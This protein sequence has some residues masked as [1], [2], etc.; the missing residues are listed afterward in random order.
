MG[1]RVAS[2]R[3]APAGTRSQVSGGWRLARAMSV[4]GF[5]AVLAVPALEHPGGVREGGGAVGPGDW[6]ARDFAEHG[7]DEAGG[8]AFAGALDEFDAFGDGGV[9]GDAFEIAQL[10]DAHAEGDA[11]FGIEARSADVQGGQVIELRLVAQDAEDDF[12]GQAGIAGVERARRA[13]PAGL[14]RRR[15]FRR[16]GGRRRRSARAGDTLHCKGL[17]WRCEATDAARLR[18]APGTGRG[19]RRQLRERRGVA[20]SATNTTPAAGPRP[21]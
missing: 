15:R 3:G 4:G 14:R 9:R 11:D 17:F 21:R 13:R 5:G 19:R 20:R 12:R 8:G 1:S 18:A 6:V 10:V 7:V 16:R 2:G